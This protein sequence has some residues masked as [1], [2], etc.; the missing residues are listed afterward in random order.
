MSESITPATIPVESPNP[1]YMWPTIGSALA[2]PDVSLILLL[3][4]SGLKGAIASLSRAKAF[5]L[6]LIVAPWLPSTLGGS[7]RSLRRK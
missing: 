2:V 3:L 6:L 4:G 5:L 1:P 7:H